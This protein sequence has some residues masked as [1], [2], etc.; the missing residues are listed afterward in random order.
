MACLE[1]TL[2]RERFYAGKKIV[3]I[4]AD[5]AERWHSPAAG[6]GSDAGADAVSSQ[7]QCV[8]R[9]ECAHGQRVCLQLRS[10]SY[11]IHGLHPHLRGETTPPVVTS[12][13]HGTVWSHR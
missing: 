5:E 1:R 12:L 11:M 9:R 8:V 10:G 4:E 6:S 3:A 2:S 7:V 13:P